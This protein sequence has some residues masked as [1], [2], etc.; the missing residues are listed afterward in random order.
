MRIVGI[1]ILKLEMH[2]VLDEFYVM[3]RAKQAISQVRFPPITDGFHVIFNIFQNHKSTYFLKIKNDIFQNSQ[4]HGGK[5][6]FLI[7]TKNLKSKFVQ[8]V[9]NSILTQHP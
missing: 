6:Y 3:Y 4:Y 1:E 9:K 7:T 8:N 5:Q 2:W